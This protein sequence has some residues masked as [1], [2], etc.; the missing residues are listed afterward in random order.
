LQGP[1][2]FDF[3]INQDKLADTIVPRRKFVL[4]SQELLDVV[5]ENDIVVAVKT[6]GEIHRDGLMHR[7]VHILLF[8]RH[9]QL[10]L[11]KRSLTKDEQPGKWDSSAAG[12]VDSGEDY[13]A[14]ARRE[15]EEE[16]G[17]VAEHPLQPLFKLPASALTGNEHCMVYLY[18]FDG[19]L[20]LQ[21]DE[22][23]DG[24]W[25]GPETMDARVARQDP[26]LTEAVG[27]IWK[28]YRELAHK[29]D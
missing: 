19:S 26:E 23:D 20:V 22:I 9:G 14:C 10:F 27:L 16:L 11:Q 17:I 4:V 15:I 8:N 1:R 29:T 28:K 24:A 2:Q 5:D 12:H 3:A 13:L 25:I 7:A 21:A 18:H 6:R